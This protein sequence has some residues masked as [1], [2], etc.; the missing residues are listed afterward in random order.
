MAK[1]DKIVELQNLLKQDPKNIQ[2]R[3]QLAIL[4][5]DCG[6]SEEALKNLLYLSKNIKN[7]SD[8]YYNLGIV[9]EK[10]K[11]LSKAKEAYEKSIEIAPE[12]TYGSILSSL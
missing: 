10:L 8:I 12:K 6:F 4:L 3:R 7:D 5:I 9:Y 1:I 11:N 2:A